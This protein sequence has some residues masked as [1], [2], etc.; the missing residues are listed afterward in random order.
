[1]FQYFWILWSKLNCLT[2]FKMFRA[3]IN[4]VAS[5]IP[6]TSIGVNSLHGLNPLI[7]SL[8]F[9]RLVGEN[10]KAYILPHHYDSCIRQQ[11]S[12][13]AFLQRNFVHGYFATRAT[14]RT[15]C[16]NAADAICFHPVI[17]AMRC[18]Q[19]EPKRSITAKSSS[20]CRQNGRE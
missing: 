15:Q 12:F 8:S 11:H 17:V 4:V 7:P 5:W 2:C 13:L 10:M 3:Y 18:C 14:L 16:P 6:G 19:G 20:G 1:M 9:L